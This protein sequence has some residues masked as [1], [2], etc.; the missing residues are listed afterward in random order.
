MALKTAPLVLDSSCW[1][2][3]FNDS[4][5]ADLFAAVAQSPAGLIVPIITIYEVTKKLR[6]EISP[7]VA[8]YAESMMRRGR[9]VDLDATLTRLAITYNLPLADSLIYATAQTHNAVL[10]TQ[11]A[12]FEGLVGV[13][14]FA[15]NKA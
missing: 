9:V 4:A 5:R 15:K 8:G 1:L 3:Y 12:H 13:N 10:W 6:R 7:T 2:E 11:D 14:Y